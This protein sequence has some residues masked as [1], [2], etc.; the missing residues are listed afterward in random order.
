VAVTRQSTFVVPIR[1]SDDVVRVRQVVREHA[2]QCGFSL[3]DQTKLV[4]AASELA[5]NTLE[6]GGG[7][8][9]ELSIVLNGSRSGLCITFSD[10]GPGIPSIEDALR[11][12]FSTGAGLGLGLGGARRL[13]NEFEIRSKPGA[14]TRVSITRWR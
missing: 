8:E 9:A 14:G 11:D 6:H 7:G 10:H 4:T 12:G 3:V 1:A 5:R 13:S 2:R